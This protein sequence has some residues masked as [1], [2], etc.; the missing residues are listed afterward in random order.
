MYRTDSIDTSRGAEGAVAAVGGAGGTASDDGAG[1][2]A[3]AEAGALCAGSGSTGTTACEGS[4]C[5]TTG[6]GAAAGRG[7]MGV[8]GLVA[9]TG[10]GGRGTEL[11]GGD[12]KNATM[13]GISTTGGVRSS[14]RANTTAPCTAK[15]NAKTR[16]RR[17]VAG[18]RNKNADIPRLSRNERRWSH[19]REPGQ[20]LFRVMP[21]NLNG[22]VATLFPRDKRHL[23]AGASQ[24]IGQ[25]IDERT[26]GPPLYRARL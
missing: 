18:A 22:L 17:R 11:L 4:G 23:T 5:A 2:A 8:G 24:P 15:T 19:C 1:N 21:I 13:A 14:S 12:T 3:V 7:M 26:I 20:D 10:A 9:T 25:P 6:E 16:V